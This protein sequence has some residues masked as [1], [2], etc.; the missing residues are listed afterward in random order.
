MPNTLQLAPVTVSHH[1]PEIQPPDF[2]FDWESTPRSLLRN[3]G[4]LFQ[5]APPPL[6]V[7]SRPATFWPDVFVRRPLDKRNFLISAV[8]H[9]ALVAGL[10][11][12]PT[13]MLLTQPAYHPE[14]P[15]SRTLTYYQVSEYLPP[16]QSPVAPA[17]RAQ[18]GEPALAKQ[19]INSVR[20]R[21]D[22][23]EQTVIDPSSVKILPGH[24][25]L[26]NLVVATPVQAAP[27]AAIKR[28]TAKLEFPIAQPMQV[29]QPAVQATPRDMSKMKMPDM[30]HASVV[31]P[32][33]DSVP[34]AVGAINIA[35]PAVQVEAPKLLTPEQRASG[36]NEQSGSSQRN[37]DAKSVPPPPVI[38]GGT[39]LNAAGQLLAL[40]LH[41]DVVEGPI[42]I[43][44]GN[45]NGEFAAGPSGRPN[46]PGTPE[47]KAAGD[48][49]GGT[50][51]NA[52]GAKRG[53]G[54]GTGAGSAAPA[55]TIGAGPAQ[56]TAAGQGATVQAPVQSKPPQND[57]AQQLSSLTKPHIPPEREL[58]SNPENIEDS[59]FGAKKY[60]SLILNMPNLSSAGGS[61]VIRFAE[62]AEHPAPGELLAPVAVQK[63]DPAYPPDLMEDRIEG[64]VTLYAVIRSDG[65]VDDVRVL[66]SVD[67]RLDE[68]ARI[69]ITKWHFRPATKNGAPV[70]LEAVI[71]IPFKLRKLPF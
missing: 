55:I 13:W 44:G 27:S 12:Y 67:E 37:T 1:R 60:Y 31:P 26:P 71:K 59:I 16:I 34:R 39:G 64:T 30:P 36:S 50:G 46:A 35:R 15:T 3:L 51:A 23:H 62:L 40:G 53:A 17:K 45:R 38:S 49:A 29:V 6:Q 57:D 70:D 5:P 41:P 21:P 66:Q 9:A 10:Y 69:A 24:I 43:P 65:R 14:P 25:R 22:N 54:S 19:V 28:S 52:N 63:V 11:L 56:P 4:D 61:W 48:S 33:L 8:Y 47:L 18:K 7:T 32:P 20:E 68:N 58:P 2:R 42:S